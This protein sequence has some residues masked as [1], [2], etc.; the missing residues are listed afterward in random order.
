MVLSK[1]DDVG[2]AVVKTGYL[3]YL[4]ANKWNPNPICAE[5][6]GALKGGQAS[7]QQAS[8]AS[9]ESGRGNHKAWSV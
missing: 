7:L 8:R 9:A 2:V 5:G 6:L 1:M 3:R 4:R